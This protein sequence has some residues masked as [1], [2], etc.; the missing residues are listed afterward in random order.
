MRT[1]AVDVDGVLIDY[2]GAAAKWVGRPV[3]DVVDW[4]IFSSLG[5]PGLWHAWDEHVA[6]PGFCFKLKP[7]HQRGCM[8]NGEYQCSSV[9]F[10]RRLRHMGHRVIFAT[11]PHKN[12]PFWKDERERVLIEQWD[13]TR[14]DVVFAH[15]KSLVRADLLID[16]K[17]QNVIN[18][19]GPAICF[20]QPWNRDFE[21]GEYNGHNKYR[22]NG[23]Q[24]VLRLV[25]G[26]LG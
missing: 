4:D 1:V 15:D 6:K 7:I 18:F 24:E 5:C 22:A 2:V 13:A 25:D 14:G 23:Y 10:V 19:V 20:S 26:I 3:T 17:P 21:A 11:S 16:D 12:A 9:E 8:I